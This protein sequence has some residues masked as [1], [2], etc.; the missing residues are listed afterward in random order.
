M[1]VNPIWYKY[2]HS[3]DLCSET[4]AVDCL[5]YLMVYDKMHR[6]LE[7][8]VSPSL[9]FPTSGNEQIKTTGIYC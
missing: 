2:C 6:K 3:E 4:I 8:F 7:A 1:Y 9:R 5:C